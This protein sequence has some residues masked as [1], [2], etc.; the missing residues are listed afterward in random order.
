MDAS[1]AIGAAVNNSA[2]P[3]QAWSV[4]LYPAAGVSR[5]LQLLAMGSAPAL[6]ALALEDWLLGEVLSGI[7]DVQAASFAAP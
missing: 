7:A 3:A 4:T 2:A 5:S 1:G 6:P